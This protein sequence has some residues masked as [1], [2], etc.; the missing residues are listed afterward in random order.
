MFWKNHETSQRLGQEP[1]EVENRSQKQESTKHGNRKANAEVAS[2]NE[3]QSLHSLNPYPLITQLKL[4]LLSIGND[5]IFF[6]T[7]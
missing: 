5:K 4:F 6:P 7:Y 1:A 2:S 3:R